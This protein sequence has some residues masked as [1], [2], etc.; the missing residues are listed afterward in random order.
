[1]TKDELLFRLAGCAENPDEEQAHCEA[2]AAL[3]EYIADD[4]IA[5]AYDKVG[6]WYA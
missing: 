5:A 3:V 2:D 6:K 4:E 1:M